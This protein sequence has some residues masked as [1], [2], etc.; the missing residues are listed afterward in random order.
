MLDSIRSNSSLRHSNQGQSERIGNQIEIRAET[1]GAEG[2]ARTS[3]GARRARKSTASSGLGK[4]GQTIPLEPRMDSSLAPG[5][6]SQLMN[7]CNVLDLQTMTLSQNRENVYI[8]TR[9]TEQT[10]QRPKRKKKI[11]VIK[12]VKNPDGSLVTIR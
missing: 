12:K 5:F 11:I 10:P 9:G 8:T 1:S 2:P 6:L 7:P 3:L 4:Q